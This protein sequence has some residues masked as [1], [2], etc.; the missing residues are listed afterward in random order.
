MV[1][2]YTLCGY[3]DFWERHHHLSRYWLQSVNWEF[4]KKTAVPVTSFLNASMEK[5]EMMA[6]MM[7]KCS[8]KYIT[9]K[10]ITVMFI[11]TEPFHFH[12][13]DW[14]NE[15][16]IVRLPGMEKERKKNPWLTG[17]RMQTKYVMIWMKPTSDFKILWEEE[18]SRVVNK[19]RRVDE[20]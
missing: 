14:E 10:Y 13:M 12:M 19:F 18:I 3:K 17:W 6:I 2:H 16:V 8:N 9:I 7:Q 20:K 1:V 5:I 11:P 4:V 15:N